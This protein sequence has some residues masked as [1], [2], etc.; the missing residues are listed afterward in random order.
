[1]NRIQEGALMFLSF[2]VGGVTAFWGLGT[3]VIYLD[4]KINGERP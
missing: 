4:K 2:I 1:M 3:L